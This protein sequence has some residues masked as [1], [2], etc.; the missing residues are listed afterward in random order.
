MNYKTT[1]SN[2]FN[3]RVYYS[4]LGLEGVY[5][6]YRVFCE[7]NNDI[8]RLTE[9]SILGTPKYEELKFDL[10][11]DK[12]VDKINNLVNM[13]SL[14]SDSVMQKR[15]ETAEELVI[16]VIEQQYKMVSDAKVQYYGNII[17]ACGK[18][19]QQLIQNTLKQGYLNVKSP[20]YH[21]NGKLVDISDFT[22]DFYMKLAR[23]K[24][25]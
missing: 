25:V 22:L 3:E 13:V 1:V 15:F 4:S 8:K 20:I 24:L 12:A 7:I 2:D 19:L 21:I 6:V 11:R 9:G 17:K 14:S 18:A 23:E 10:L 5:E 16:K